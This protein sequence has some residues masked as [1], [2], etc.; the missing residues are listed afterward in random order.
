MHINH[1][2]CE[3]TGH[4]EIQ[5]VTTLKDENGNDYPSYHRFVISPHN[6]EKLDATLTV[7]QAQECKDKWALLG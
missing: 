7:E 2:Y 4:V 3:P 6:V 5:E 1:K